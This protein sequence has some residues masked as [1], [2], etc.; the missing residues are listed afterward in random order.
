MLLPKLPKPQ[1]TSEPKPK[2][3]GLS[4]ATEIDVIDPKRLFHQGG[5]PVSCTDALNIF[6]NLY[7]S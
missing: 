7:A 3:Y 6:V 2:N 4:D 5:L 1:L